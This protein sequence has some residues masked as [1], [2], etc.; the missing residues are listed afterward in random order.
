M[1]P[2]D[3][4]SK[5]WLTLDSQD[6][7]AL[8]SL[9]DA[10]TVVFT[11][12]E[13]NDCFALA[14]AHE[15]L[16]SLRILLNSR[17]RPSHGVL[18]RVF[19]DLVQEGTRPML[20]ASIQEQVSPVVTAEYHR[21]RQSARENNDTHGSNMYLVDDLEHDVL[22]HF[23]SKM[24]FYSD[25]VLTRSDIR[26]RGRHIKETLRHQAWMNEMLLEA[27]RRSHKLLLCHLLQTRST[28]RP[29]QNAINLAFRESLERDQHTVSM[30]LGAW[31]D[32]SSVAV[33][34]WGCVDQAGYD[35]AFE[36][37]SDM[38]DIDSLKFL[39]N[40]R[41]GFRPTQALIDFVYQDREERSYME[42]MSKQTQSM[43]PG[44]RGVEPSFEAH[45]SKMIGELLAIH[46]SKECLMTVFEMKKQMRQ[47]SD[48]IHR[49][50]GMFRQNRGIDIHDY[51]GARVQGF[52]RNQVNPTDRQT[53]NQ[54][55]RGPSLNQTVIN[56][57]ENRLNAIGVFNIEYDISSMTSA[58]TELIM[59]TFTDES[60]Q[61]K[62]MDIVGAV[63][64][65]ESLR[66]FSHT[67]TFLKHLSRTSPEQEEVNLVDIWMHGFL[68]ESIVMRSCNPGA[69]DRVVTGLRGIGDPELDAIFGQAEGP[70]LARA[71]LK[72]TMNIFPPAD[73]IVE[74]QQASRNARNLAAAL[75][76]EYSV[77]D[78]TPQSDVMNKIKLYASDSIAKYGVNIAEYE[79]DIVAI[80]E[81]I[82]DNYETYLQP[83]II[84]RVN[85]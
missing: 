58:L 24:L 40:G 51:A 68:S 74:Q 19:A 82:V 30:I 32:H 34:Q 53:R 27:G 62:A 4:P 55:R 7:K 49:R 22:S 9:V 45:R 71:F 16:D 36:N 5:L 43:A 33:F 8:C 78:E 83:Y 66:V 44:G 60:E 20:T 63:L 77:T 72:G 2:P 11:V 17:F 10:A 15:D 50:N 28:L 3:G 38:D 25:T 26:N 14:V 31:G 73:N 57:V 70:H 23:K 59:R 48:V 18:Q 29:S 21:H 42:S 6:P 37:A 39:L 54:S 84:E 35:D 80:A 56:H 12:S 75:V 52:S 65:N 47:T 1:P 46:A 67:L 64:N 85:R 79:A 69:L 61:G 76:G 13:C 81:M 41:L